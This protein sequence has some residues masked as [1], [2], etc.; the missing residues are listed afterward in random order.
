MITIL[1]RRHRGHSPQPRLRPRS[2][3]GRVVVSR[4]RPLLLVGMC[5]L[6]VCLAACSATGAANATG[7]SPTVKA[8]PT[9]THGKVATPTQSEPTLAGW[10][11]VWDSEFNAGVFDSSKW[12]PIDSTIPS[13]AGCCAQYANQQWSPSNVFVSGGALHLVTEKKPSGGRP[14]TS[15]A[16]TTIGK[17]SFLYGRVD[18]RAKLPT[19]EGLWPAAWLLPTTGTGPWYS[20]YEIDLIEAWGS[21][22]TTAHFFFHWRTGQ[23][24]CE[25]N[26]PNFSADYHT[27]TLIWTPTLVEW[28]VDG[29]THCTATNDIPPTPMYLILSAAIDGKLESTNAKT[30][31]PQSFDIDYVRVWSAK[32]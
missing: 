4:A 31:L 19:T 17:F 16:V 32:N 3:T 30:V 25:V 2:D 12:Q 1:K 29:V 9:A 7:A 18:I 26:G 5:C 24:G 8:Q 13:T 20:P 6:M 22:P 27:Y 23:H 21:Q 10:S 14:Y 28:Q 15:G 11:L